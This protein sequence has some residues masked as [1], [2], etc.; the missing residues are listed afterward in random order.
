MGRKLENCQ[1]NIGPAH[2]FGVSLVP[3]D[4]PWEVLN[5]MLTYAARGTSTLFFFEYV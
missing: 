1:Q 2:S 3:I 5:P 4:F